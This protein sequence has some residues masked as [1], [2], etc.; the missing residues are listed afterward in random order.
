M[1]ASGIS[2]SDQNLEQYADELTVWMSPNHKLLDLSPIEKDDLLVIG[3][4]ADLEQFE[5]KH[6]PVE[7]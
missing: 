1:E 6:T 2:K 5:K 3:S 7:Y 4:Q